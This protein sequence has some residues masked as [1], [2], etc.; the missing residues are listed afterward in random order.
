MLFP[1]K[2]KNITLKRGI[3]LRLRVPILYLRHK[4]QNYNG[5]YAILLIFVFQFLFL[6]PKRKDLRNILLRVNRCFKPK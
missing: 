3:M 1:S 4:C 6:T 2:L 5:K